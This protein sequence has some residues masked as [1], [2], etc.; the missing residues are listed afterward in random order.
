MSTKFCCII[1]ISELGLNLATGMFGPDEEGPSARW[2]GSRLVLWGPDYAPCPSILLP[3]H[4]SPAFIGQPAC[5]SP[6][7]SHIHWV[8]VSSLLKWI[9]WIRFSLLDSKIMTKS[10]AFKH[11][12]CPGRTN[13]IICGH[14]KW[15]HGAPCSKIIKNFKSATAEHQTKCRTLHL[16]SVGPCGT[17]EVGCTWSQP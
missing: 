15:K 17:A 8:S 5:C 4:L 3:S 2:L 6:C 13:Y 11:I 9:Y 1:D 16:L 10:E 7:A 12:P 14:A